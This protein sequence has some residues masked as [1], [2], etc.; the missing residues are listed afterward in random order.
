MPHIHPTSIVSPEAQIADDVEIG[1]FCIVEG[2]VKI[3]SGTKLLS[4]VV[5]YSGA[6][7]GKNNKIFPGSVIA[8][9][10]QDLKFN[11]EYTEVFIGDNNTIREAVTIS[12]ATSATK[13]TIVGNNNLLM[14]YVHV[15]HDCVVGNNCVLA[16]CVELAGHVHVEDYVIIGGLTGVHQ[17]T[18]IGRHAMIGACSKIVKDIP[19]YSLFSGNPVSYEGLNI[20][21]LRRRGFKEE[22]I[23][24]LKSA[25]SIL[26]NSAFNTTQAINNIKEVVKSTE[27]VQHLLK[28]IQQS[29]RG[30]SK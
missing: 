9:V 4:H 25:F 24:S 23:S 3:N 19:P 11:N 13:R 16:N 6:R 2:D 10:P 7:I 17:F 27:E 14:A 8:A 5:I 20:I 28:F 29:R 21:G 26:Y 22:A 30:I 18:S 15:A 1:P 12:R